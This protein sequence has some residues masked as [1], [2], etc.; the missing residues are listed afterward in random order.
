M[1]IT[2]PDPLGFGHLLEFLV[3]E[4]VALVKPG[5]MVMIAV[6]SGAGS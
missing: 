2:R 3:C 1:L 4:K 6:K 5:C